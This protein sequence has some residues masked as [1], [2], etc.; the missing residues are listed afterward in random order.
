MTPASS[1]TQIIWLED[2]VDGLEKRLKEVE[3]LNKATQPDWDRRERMNEY[4]FSLKLTVDKTGIVEFSGIIS[5]KTK[6]EIL[7]TLMRDESS[8]KFK[9]SKE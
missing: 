3:R 7:D 8:D 1:K 5:E 4:K 6:N 9:A 2:R